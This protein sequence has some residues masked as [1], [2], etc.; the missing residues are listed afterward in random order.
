M[1]DID[2][3]VPPK[4]N[5]DTRTYFKLSIYSPSNRL[6]TVN[7]EMNSTYSDA[8][9]LES[10]LLGPGFRLSQGLARLHTQE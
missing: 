1:A 2:S 7:E 3:L 10:S 9:Q 5:K 8:G 4:F 6:F